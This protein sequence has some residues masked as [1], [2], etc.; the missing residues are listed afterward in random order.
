MDASAGKPLAV[1]RKDDDC[2]WVLFKGKPMPIMM[3]PGDMLTVVYKVDESGEPQ[4]VP[5]DAAL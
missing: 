5:E 1:Y 4:I 3:R 2:I